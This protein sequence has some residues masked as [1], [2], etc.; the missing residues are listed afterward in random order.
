MHSRSCVGSPLGVGDVLKREIRK[1]IRDVKGGS[2]STDYE[3][4]WKMMY[5]VPCVFFIAGAFH[6]FDQDLIFAL[7]D[8]IVDGSRAVL[9]FSGEKFESVVGPFPMEVE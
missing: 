7:P 3:E 1:K 5:P 9:R 8:F 6:C 4:F 2:G